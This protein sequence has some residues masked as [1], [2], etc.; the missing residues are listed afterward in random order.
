MTSEAFNQR[1]SW[2]KLS[3]YIFALFKENMLQG[4]RLVNV[5]MKTKVS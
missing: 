2:K 4:K 1:K 3:Q 5:V